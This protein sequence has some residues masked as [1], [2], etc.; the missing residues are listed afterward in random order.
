[1][2]RFSLY[3]IFSAII[4]LLFPISLLIYLLFGEKDI[5][6][7]II[8][9]AFLSYVLV[10][11]FF[12]VNCYYI[13]YILEENGKSF[14]NKWKTGLRI[15]F[16]CKK[17]SPPNFVYITIAIIYHSLANINDFLELNKVVSENPSHD[18]K[19]IK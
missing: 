4:S 11:S 1:M 2:K 3:C 15:L 5:I 19:E 13:Q 12:R 10:T 8:L 17:I 16:C 14:L 9:V 7:I 6:F 18:L